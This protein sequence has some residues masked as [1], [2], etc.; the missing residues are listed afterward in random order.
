MI[1]KFN[2]SKHLAAFYSGHIGKQLKDFYYRSVKKLL[3]IKA[4]PE[5]ETFL[6]E[7]MGQAYAKYQDSAQTLATLSGESLNEQ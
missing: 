2:Y 4:N 5:K 3:N 1:S 6:K 7:V